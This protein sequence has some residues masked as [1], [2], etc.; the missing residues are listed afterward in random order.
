[1]EMTCKQA[2]AATGQLASA[3]ADYNQATYAQ[4][5][6]PP[7]TSPTQF[8][9]SRVITPR[10]LKEHKEENSWRRKHQYL[11][12]PFTEKKFHSFF[13]ELWMRDELELNSRAVTRP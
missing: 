7:N 10:P 11:G 5:F 6:R 2:S 3:K 13:H 8:Y 1:M 9:S 4:A 12:L